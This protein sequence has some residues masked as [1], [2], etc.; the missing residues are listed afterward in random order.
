MRARR[1][2]AET[3]SGVVGSHKYLSVTTDH[4]HNILTYREDGEKGIYDEK[5][6]D[7]GRQ[8]WQH[9]LPLLDRLGR[10]GTTSPGSAYQIT[11]R[12]AVSDCK[13]ENERRK[14]QKS[15][16]GFADNHIFPADM[17]KHDYDRHPNIYHLNGYIVERT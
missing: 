8:I 5:V 16:A 9:L 11:K 17:L 4:N 13:M 12:A 15:M 1:H 14:H 10:D 7:Q 2:L 3:P 6:L